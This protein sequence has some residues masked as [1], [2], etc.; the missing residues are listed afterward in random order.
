[1]VGTDIHTL[2]RKIREHIRTRGQSVSWSESERL[3]IG[4][5]GLLG[6]FKGQAVT[7]ILH[8]LLD[9]CL[10]SLADLYE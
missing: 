2:L 6:G 3:S 7:F 5:E 1:M 9:C 10:L 4:F 8:E